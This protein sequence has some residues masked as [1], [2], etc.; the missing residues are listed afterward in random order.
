MIPAPKKE[1]AMVRP[2]NEDHHISADLVGRL[3]ERRH[4]RDLDDPTA[5]GKALDEFLAVNFVDL[6][7]PPRASA[8]SAYVAEV[9]SRILIGLIELMLVFDLLPPRAVAGLFARIR[10]GATADH[11]PAPI[12]GI[13]ARYAERFG[14]ENAAAESVSKEN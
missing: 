3:I 4:L 8:Q 11:L 9:T 5:I 2:N 7:Q 13:L 1:A 6:P 14:V 12:Y 10:A